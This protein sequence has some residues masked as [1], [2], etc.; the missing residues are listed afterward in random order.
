MDHE[1]LALQGCQLRVLG[2]LF[3]IT[4]KDERGR[5]YVRHIESGKALGYIKPAP[6]RSPFKWAITSLNADGNSVVTYGA[7]PQAHTLKIATER[8]LLS[9]LRNCEYGIK[10]NRWLVASKTTRVEWLEFT[11]EA[12]P[13]LAAQVAPVMS[14]LFGGSDAQR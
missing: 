7:T 3:E 11:E 10:H 6:D 13:E 8:L 9:S 2:V 1:R 14:A 5:R 12:T 4:P